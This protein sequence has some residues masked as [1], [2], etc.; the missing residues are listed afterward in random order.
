MN[1]HESVKSKEKDAL[2]LA[3]LIY[4]IFVEKKKYEASDS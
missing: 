1:K 4:D 3:G 2:A